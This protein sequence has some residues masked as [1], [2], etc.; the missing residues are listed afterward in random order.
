MSANAISKS[1]RLHRWVVVALLA[2]LNAC[3]GGSGMGSRVI[4]H[5]ISTEIKGTQNIYDIEVLYGKEVISFKGIAR[6]GGGG[7]WNAPMSVPNE[8]TVRWTTKGQRQEAVIPLTGKV[9]PTFLLKRWRLYFY[10]ESLELWREEQTGP[11]SSLT[12]LQPRQ[13]V[14]VYP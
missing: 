10:D 3:A 5:G 1:S 12:G 9:S 13:S 7:G 8:M 14:K 6:P 2:F 11:T 4:E